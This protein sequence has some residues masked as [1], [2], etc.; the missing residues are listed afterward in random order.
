MCGIAGFTQPDPDESLIRRMTATITHRGPDQQGTY[1][2]T[3]VALGAVRLQVID[4]DGG[5]QPAR[6][7]IETEDG[8]TVIVYN[9]EIYNFR[10]LRRELESLGHRFRSDCD[11]EVALRAFLQWD[12]G[13]FER[14]R[15]MF[16]MAIWCERD[17]RLVLARDRLGIK[18]LYIRRIGPDLVFGSELKVLFEH[19]DVTRQL[20]LTALSDFLS[21]LYVPAPRT[22]VEGIEKLPSGH[23]LEWR[24]GVSNL[25]R[26]WKLSFAPDPRI[27]EEDARQE[28]DRLL[29]ESVK[30]ELVSDVPLGVWSS[31]GIDSST[32]LHYASEMGAKPI[33]TFSMV[34]ESKSCDESPYFREIA[35]IYGTEHHEFELNRDSEIVS[36]I[37]DFAFYSDEPGADAG[38]LPVWFLSKMSRQYVTVALSGEGGDELFGGY[39]TYRADAL[40]RYLRAVPP[41]FRE[42]ALAAAHVLLPASDEKIGF[43]YKLKR[44]IEGS[45]LHPDEA[46]LFWNGAFSRAQKAEILPSL[47][48][49]DLRRLSAGLPSAREIGFL[50]RYLMLDQQYYLQ[51]NLLCKVDRMSMAHSLEVRPPLLDHRIVEYA[52]RLPERLKIDGAKQKVILKSLMRD[53]LPQSVLT[54]KKA[55]LDIPAHEWFRG[56]LLPLFEDALNERAARATGLFDYAAIRKLVEEH[57]SRKINAGYQLW[58]L[59]TLFLWL[60]KWRI[61]RG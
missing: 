9:G 44:G 35:K 33:K 31:G 11:T 18:P 1:V 45:L 23:Y 26:Y 17:R 49:H 46:H 8:Q 61:G 42:A 27:T 10:E 19:P 57:T 59:L 38:A 3:G 14:L 41:V 28:L 58:A 21:L 32:L 15:G 39:L 6:S 55:G 56:P 47:P 52:S 50:N 13:C 30:E 34:F 40:A 25:V 2:S 37:E 43:E 22:L 60:R 20:D 7:G 5:E 51:D 48:F 29:R 54:R 16:A 24:D 36:A 12:T 4:L 53:K